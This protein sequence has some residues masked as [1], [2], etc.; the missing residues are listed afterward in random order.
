MKSLRG[1]SP[2]PGLPVPPEPDPSPG[3]VRDPEP[4]PEPEP[5][6]GP[7]VLP[8]PGPDRGPGLPSLWLWWPADRDFG[9]LWDRAI[10]WS[11]GRS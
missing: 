6:T 7:D 3:P 9:V 8:N 1:P 10:Y 4:S 2:I 11:N 5:G